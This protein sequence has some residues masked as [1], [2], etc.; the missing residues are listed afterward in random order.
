MK[1]KKTRPLILCV[2]FAG[3]LATASGCKEEEPVMESPVEIAN[4]EVKATGMFSSDA[5]PTSGTV[6][7]EASDS[8]AVLIFEGFKTDDGPDLRVYLS[9]DK[10]INDAQ[11]IGN[12]KG[13]AGDF[14]YTVSADLDYET[15]DHVLIWCEDFS[16]LFGTCILS[17]P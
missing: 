10:T 4:S 9:V 13:V 2:A 16:V 12:L 6:T 15:Y 11:M 7:F 17:E 5:H 8:E 3:L 14:S 1:L